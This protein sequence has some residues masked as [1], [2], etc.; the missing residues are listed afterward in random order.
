MYQFRLK[1]PVCGWENNEGCL[2]SCPPQYDFQCRKQ[3]FFLAFYERENSF[4][5]I[6]Q[7]ELDEYY[8][9]D[10]NVIKG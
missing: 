7:E 4:S 9:K 8:A 3:D 5:H 1:C 2:A 10:I 6:T